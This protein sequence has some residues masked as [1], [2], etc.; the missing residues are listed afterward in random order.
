MVSRCGNPNYIGFKRYG[1]RGIVVCNRW[2]AYENFLADMGEPETGMSLDRID[3]NGNYSPENCR[4]ATIREQ[5]LNK[6][7][8]RRW[9]FRGE[10][11][12][13]KEISE[14]TGVRP[15]TLEYRLTQRWS[16]ELIASAPSARPHRFRTSKDGALPLGA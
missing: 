7:N 15:Y 8:T 9:R 4:W 5:S 1:G 6:R 12:T 10:M 16:D 2:R 14:A 3:P 13:L 11:L